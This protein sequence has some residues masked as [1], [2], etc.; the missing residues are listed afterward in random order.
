MLGADL[1][2][3]ATDRAAGLSGAS[4]RRCGYGARYELSGSYGTQLCWQCYFSRM[5]LARDAEKRSPRATRRAGRAFDLVVGAV[6]GAIAS[7]IV[8]V[9]FTDA[10]TAAVERVAWIVRHPTQQPSCDEP[11]WYEEV[12]PSD[13]QAWSE[14]HEGD[15]D[16]LRSTALMRDGDPNTSWLGRDVDDPKQNQ[17]AFAFKD[18]PKLMFACIQNGAVANVNTYFGNGRIKEYNLVGCS[19]TRVGEFPDLGGTAS[20]WNYTEARSWRQLDLDCVTD[21]LVLQVLSTHAQDRSIQDHV[22]DTVS[23]SEIR[24]YSRP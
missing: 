23:I 2:H 15:E 18:R 14:L 4:I 7:L 3:A 16:S 17:V 24:F 1:S 12:V 11:G 20:S 22:G 19:E 13:A 9:I 8:G 10:A 21:S 5:S 6:L